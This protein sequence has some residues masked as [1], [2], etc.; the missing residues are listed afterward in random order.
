[1][2]DV[3]LVQRVAGESQQSWPLKP[4]AQIIGRGAHCEIVIDDGTISREHAQL[5]LDD[6]LVRLIDLDSRNGTYVDNARI[7]SAVVGRGSVLQFGRIVCA[8]S[9]QPISVVPPRDPPSTLPY[10]TEA[11]VPEIEFL[12]EKKRLVLGLLLDGLSEKEIA[13][14]LAL[15]PN[16][17]H[18]HV[19]DLYRVFEV[20]SRGE[21]LALFVRK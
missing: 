3:F 16:T 6:R 12:S 18:H 9:Q 7:Q 17:V 19:T 11:T 2:A 8:I 5:I 15:S 4:G 21:L 13:T 14:K 20:S 10:E 1:M